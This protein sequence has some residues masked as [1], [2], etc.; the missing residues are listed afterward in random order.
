MA[1]LRRSAWGARAAYA[2]TGFLTLVGPAVVVMAIT[3]QVNDD[4]NADT[5]N[6]VMMS[7][8]GLALAALGVAV[9]Q[10]AVND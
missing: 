2:V 10:H 4:P 8:V 5:A 3:M 6:V 7:V 1:P 9:Y